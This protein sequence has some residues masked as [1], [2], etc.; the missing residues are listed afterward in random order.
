[1]SDMMREAE[2]RQRERDCFKA[3]DKPVEAERERVF[4][5]LAI[6]SSLNSRVVLCDDVALVISESS[7]SAMVCCWDLNLIV[8]MISLFLKSVTK[9]ES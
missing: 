1:M 3:T 6:S 2:R 4:H 5:L 9:S 7:G 8:P